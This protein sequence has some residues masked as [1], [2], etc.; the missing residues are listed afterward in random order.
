MPRPLVLVIED[1]RPVRDLLRQCLERVGCEVIAEANGKSGLKAARRD[2]PDLILMDMRLPGLD[3]PEVLDKLRRTRGLE[4]VPVIGISGYAH[5]EMKAQAFERGCVAFLEKPLV[6]SEV[7]GTVLEI[8][9]LT[10]PE[11]ETE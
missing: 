1:N 5:P 6:L 2:P 7:G 4:R 10:P 9:G 8:L 3:G 11:P